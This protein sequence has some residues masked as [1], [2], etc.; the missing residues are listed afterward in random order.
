ML[1]SQ[2]NRTHHVGLGQKRLAG[3]PKA[4]RHVMW[5]SE[6]YMRFGISRSLTDVFLFTSAN[7]VPER[8]AAQRAGLPREV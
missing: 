8:L 5:C 7:E 6:S 3:L 1:L 4:Y 2:M